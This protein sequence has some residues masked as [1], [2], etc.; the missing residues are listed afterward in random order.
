[1]I[2]LY[3][4][5]LT[6]NI[7]AFKKV[8]RFSWNIITHIVVFTCAFQ[9][10]F[11]VFLDIK[12]K[13]YWYGTPGVDWAL[14]PAYIFLI[15]PVNLMFL[16]WFPFNKSLL[17][18]LAYFGIWEIA[19]LSYEF[20]ALLPEPW[21]YFHYGWWSLW[22]SALVN[23]ILLVILLGYYKFVCKLENKVVQNRY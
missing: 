10:I 9:Y 3:L 4:S 12:Y 8:K 11:D 13:A 16:N 20:I 1:M 17:K 22:H 18:Q 21:G 7:L 2:I 5:I 14:L 19:L 15:P 6:L 23:P